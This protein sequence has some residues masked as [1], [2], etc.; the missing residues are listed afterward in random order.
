MLRTQ[1]AGIPVCLTVSHIDGL[2]V[3][4]SAFH[5]SLNYRAVMVFGTAE[6]VADPAAKEAGFNAFLD[7]IYPGR[8]GILRPISAQELKATTLMSMA[9]AE[10]SAK[11]R[12][13]GPIDLE[14][15]HDADCWAGLIPIAQRI[16]A[17]VSDARV[18]ARGSAAREIGHFAEGAALDAILLSLA[19]Q[20]T[21]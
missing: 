10:V 13:A 18:A 12:D 5:H 17:P 11:I 4:R 3:A 15:D 20:E 7:R 21:R 16:G 14:T 8:T 9:I 2:V 6:I 1:R 19:R